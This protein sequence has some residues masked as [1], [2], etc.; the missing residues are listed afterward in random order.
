FDQIAH[1]YNAGVFPFRIDF[2]QL[3]FQHLKVKMR[4]PDVKVAQR[5][6]VYIFVLSSVPRLY[7]FQRNSSPLLSDITATTEGLHQPPQRHCRNWGI[8]PQ[9]SARKKTP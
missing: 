7:V 9:P 1:D 6:N 8:A 5:K 3:R 4:R 2:L